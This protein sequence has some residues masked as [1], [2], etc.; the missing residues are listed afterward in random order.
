[1]IRFY[2]LPFLLVAALFAYEENFDSYRDGTTAK[3]FTD[4]GIS[5]ETSGTWEV[6]S[7]P[8]SRFDTPVFLE[9][10][11]A[12]ENAPL[13]L[14]FDTPQCRV[15]FAFATD[16]KDTLNL[17]GTYHGVEVYHHAF[18]GE[19][20]GDLYYGDLSIEKPLDALTLS[21]TGG[22]KLLI[23][24]IQTQACTLDAYTLSDHLAAHFSFDSNTSDY[25][26]RTG[27]LGNAIALES[28][29]TPLTLEV[30]AT[31]IKSIAFWFYLPEDASTI[32]LMHVMDTS[33]ADR[34]NL[35]I[36]A[37][38]R[39]SLELSEAYFSPYVNPAVIKPGAWHH[40]V[41]TRGD[42]LLSLSV[43]G[44]VIGSY[45]TAATL[46]QSG[47]TL[48]LEPDAGLLIDDLRLYNMPL[49]PSDTLELYYTREN[50]TTLAEARFEAGKQFCIDRPEACGLRSGDINAD[51]S[52]E[53]DIKA[54][55]N[56]QL[57]FS[58]Y[59]FSAVDG[60]TYL[61]SGDFTN[62]HIWQLVPGTREWKPVH[63]AG[64]FDGYDARGAIFDSVVISPD[65]TSILFGGAADANISE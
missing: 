9:P 58:W 4:S 2:I 51:L 15:T 34:S 5:F 39:P 10:G 30:P 27:M 62:P 60:S 3:S 53:H 31:T 23:D 6:F 36:L 38:G 42:T 1:M 14:R 64:A 24:S 33:G 32:T 40:A 49:S 35:K 17:I 25:T 13:T 56:Q 54:L 55:S 37:D 47:D 45:T 18:S 65:A 59:L 50:F 8:F 28:L 44:N 43:D 7:T 21:T 20:G 48:T 11:K 22:K 52:L 29:E 26:T 46:C 63:N 12:A 57:S 61:A 41:I 19:N 16:G